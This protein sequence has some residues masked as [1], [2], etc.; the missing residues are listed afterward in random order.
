MTI[1]PNA[2]GEVLYFSH[3]ELSDQALVPE[4]LTQDQCL[5]LVRSALASQKR[6]LPPSME[7]ESFSCRQGLLLFVLPLLSEPPQSRYFSVT[8]S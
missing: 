6:P 5:T 2:G 4:R 8:F 1:S 3:Q 7:V